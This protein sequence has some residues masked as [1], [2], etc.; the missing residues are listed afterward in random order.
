MTVQGPVK[1]QQPEGMSHGGGG[2]VQGRPG[3]HK[4]ARPTQCG[5]ELY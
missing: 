5:V 3:K 1:K 2:A 4:P